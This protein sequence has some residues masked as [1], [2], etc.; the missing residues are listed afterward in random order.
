MTVHFEHNTILPL[1]GG[2]F[3]VNDTFTLS[4]DMVTCVE[5]RFHGKVQEAW[6]EYVSQPSNFGDASPMTVF[7]EHDAFFAGAFAML[8]QTIP[9]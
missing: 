6:E 4:D 1:C 8:K 9:F 3:Q 5:C 2:E 7:A